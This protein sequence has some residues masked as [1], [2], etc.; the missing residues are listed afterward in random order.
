M[1][2]K[3]KMYEVV[4][5]VNGYEITHQVGGKGYYTVI[6]REGKG[7]KEFYTFRTIKAAS[8]FCESIKAKT[9]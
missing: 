8:A 1:E 7:W 6:T 3:K 4:K 2:E 5:T 9:I